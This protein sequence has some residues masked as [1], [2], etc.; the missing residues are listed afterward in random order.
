M[1]VHVVAWEWIFEMDVIGFVVVV[2]VNGKDNMELGMEDI[3][4][5]PHKFISNLISN[6]G[7]WV[8][9]VNVA[10]ERVYSNYFEMD[11]H[12]LEIAN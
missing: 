11:V 2:E 4:D 10:K 8:E 7:F 3:V 12:K 5:G 1:V 6:I 9:M